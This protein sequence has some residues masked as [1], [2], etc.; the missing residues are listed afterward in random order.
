MDLDPATE[1]LYRQN[2]MAHLAVIDSKGRPHVTPVWA[3][4][5]EDRRL[6]FNTAV[7]R[8][9][10]RHLQVGDPV[11]VSATDPDD[12]YAY[13]QVRGRVA[14]RRLDTA[15]A[16]IDHLAK[17]YLDADSYPFRAEGE[18]RVTVVMEVES[19]TGR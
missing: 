8:V 15:D 5:D 19:I 17:K 12:E 3:D 2:V 16:D 7:G 13:A 4:V 9:K 10:D 1:K 11:A 6:W 14:E 18:Q